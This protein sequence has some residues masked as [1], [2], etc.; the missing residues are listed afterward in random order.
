MKKILLSI[1]AVVAL[2]ATTFA[3]VTKRNCADMEHHNYLIQTRKGYE[4]AFNEYQAQTTKFLNDKAQGKLAAVAIVTVPV[5][6]HVVYANATQS[7]S[8]SQAA[9]QVQVL[10]DDFARLNADAANTPTPFQAVAAG[11]NIR[12]CLAQRDPQGN[13]TSGV[14]YK[15]T[16]VTSFGTSD[17]VKSTAQ[18]GVDSWDVTRYINIWI[19]NIGGGIL[20]YGEFPT[21]NISNTWGL[22]LQYNYSGSGG[23][24]QSPFDLG[25]TGTHEFGHCFNLFHIWGDNGQC[26]A[27]DGVIDTP[28]QR[29]GTNNPAG[30]N[31]GVPTYPFQ[32]NT[33]TRPDGVA[34][35]SVTNVNGDMFMNYMD[36]TDDAAM[37]MFTANQVTRMEAVL[38]TAP[39]NV[40]QSSNA[41]TPVTLGTLDASMFSVVSPVNGS[42]SCTNSVL[43]TVVLKNMG[44]TVLTTATINYNIDGGAAQTFAWTGNLASLA[45]TNVSLTSF[46]GLSAA[47]HSFSVWV[48]SPNG[49]TDSNATNDGGSSSFTITSSSVG[50]GLPFTENFENTT[51]PPA[52]WA[53]Q[54]TNTLDALFTWTRFANTTGLTAG[55]T[56]VAKM[57]NFAGNNDI[58]GQKDAL[59]SPYLDFSAANSSLKLK[60]DVSH[61]RYSTTDIDSLNIY[62]SLNCG[63]TWNRIYTKGGTQ[64]QTVTTVSTAAFAPTA[65]TQ[66]RRDSIMLTP[67]AG[68][69]GVYVKFESRSGYGNNLFL[70][71]INIDYS[72]SVGLHNLESSLPNV[73]VNPNPSNGL[74]NLMLTN[75]SVNANTSISVVN[76]IGQTV[77]NNIKI[78]GITEN[79]A[80]DLSNLPNGVYYMLIQ[81][82]NNKAITKKIVISK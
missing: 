7:I 72:T 78:K 40:L 27:S 17:K 42:S 68:L 10:N 49:G 67:Y 39:W 51:F 24:A 73:S 20:G 6:V 38:N 41:C 82:E 32:A 37:N 61:R 50:T 31:Y 65:N 58:N 19:C 74:F 5:V 29:G 8:L 34:G 43:T 57:D 36:Y 1:S 18:G 25:R 14:D 66:W 3:Q 56:A 54:K 35:A 12:F 21:T 48:T 45:T 26:G 70:D 2:S 46:T 75:V 23:S 22:V 79:Q 71:N 33:C 80:I 55:S 64:L 15:S 77:A 63:G 69:S 44:V 16:T 62:V 30:C 60:F 53:L 59:R 81:S 11:A 52:G 47:A 4:Q 9:S 13:P 76:A 28:P